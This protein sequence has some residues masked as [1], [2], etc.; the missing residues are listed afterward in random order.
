MPFYKESVSRRIFIAVNYIVLV[1]VAVV[2]IFPMLHIVALS[3]SSKSAVNGGM[4]VVWPVDFTTATYKF[5]LKEPK[6]YTSFFISV[7][8]TLLGI[9]VNMLLTILAAYP[10]S[11]RKEKFHARGFYAWFFMITMLFGGGLI[12]TYL[13]V[14]NTHLINTVWAL[15]IPGAV[16]VFNVILLQ[17]FF[18]ELPDEISE[19]AFID[20]AGYWTTLTRILVP[21]SKPV[22][23]TL[24]LF[25]AVNHWNSWFDGMIYMND[26]SKYP[27]QTYLQ[28]IVVQVDM[29]AVSSLSDVANIAQKNSKAAQI[30]V[31]MLPILCVYPFLQ[32]YFT[33]G[34]IMGSVK[35]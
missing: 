2:C 27:L 20:G 15:I 32:K 8:R 6:F 35:G 4:V 18:K 33:K 14:Y 17:N 26:P 7:E 1:L 25:V 24:V 34:I 21:L 3:F 10:L 29:K 16:P 19:A 5:V 23:A 30:V 12:P 31:A 11:L 28:T 22:M 9:V 13:A